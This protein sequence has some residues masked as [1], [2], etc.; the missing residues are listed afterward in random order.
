[1]SNLKNRK[2]IANI[3]Q[4]KLVF[5][6]ISIVVAGTS[7]GYATLMS[8]V[9]AI[10]DNV[11]HNEIQLAVNNIPELKDFISNE[12]YEQQQLIQSQNRKIDN[13]Q[14]AILENYKLLCKMANGDC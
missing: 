11:K 14:N 8:D 10:K 5:I 13:N 1:M 9:S 12:F 6:L 4:Q 2:T 7:S 3:D